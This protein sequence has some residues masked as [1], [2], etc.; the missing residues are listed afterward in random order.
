MGTGCAVRHSWNFMI[1]SESPK[2]LLPFVF[3]GRIGAVLALAT[4]VAS[5]G[6]GQKQ[7]GAPPPPAVTVAEPTKRTLFDFDEYVGRFTAVNS[8][9]VRARVS[10][11]LDSV[12]FKDGQI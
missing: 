8:V 2:P 10:G 7:G 4:L 3:L 5:C 11:Y 12:D 6:E 9:E 1:R